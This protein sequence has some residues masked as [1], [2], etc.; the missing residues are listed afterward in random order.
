MDSRSLRRAWYSDYWGKING[1]F[2]AGNSSQLRELKSEWRL[3][4]W[5]LLNGYAARDRAITNKND[6]L[7]Y[8]SMRIIREAELYMK[9]IVRILRRFD[10]VE[11]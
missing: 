4:N 8:Q 9:R 7:Y 10:N 3:Y 1:G 2:Q 6:F 5:D 11:G